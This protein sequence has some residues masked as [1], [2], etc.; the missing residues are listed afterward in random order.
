MRGNLLAFG[1]L[2][3][4]AALDS[5]KVVAQTA[6]PSKPIRLIV[7]SAPGGGTDFTARTI[8][9]K[10][11]EA[12]GQTVIV[13]NRPG[14][15]GNIGVEIAAKASPDGHTIVMPITSFSI[16]PHLYSSLPF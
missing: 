5:T 6:Y 14:A 16:N 8:G 7:P 15:A 13:D 2:A 1:L 4:C 9:Q 11:S 12:I 10:L 3:I